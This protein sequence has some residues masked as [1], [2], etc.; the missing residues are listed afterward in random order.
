M[1]ILELMK[2]HTIVSSPDATIAEVVD[3]FDLYQLS[4]LHIVDENGKPIGSINEK[5]LSEYV[6]SRASVNIA[7][8]SVKD[9]ICT[10]E[11]TLDESSEVD[12]AIPA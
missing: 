4:V 5:Q 6:Y 8:N 12:N 11:C 9:I 2:V 3:L 7:S 10:Q 1:K